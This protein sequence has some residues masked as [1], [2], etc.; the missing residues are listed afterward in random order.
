MNTG[1]Q[2]AA[3]TKVC[4]VIYFPIHTSFFCLMLINMLDLQ[5]ASYPGV[6][7]KCCVQILCENIVCKVCVKILC[8]NIVCKYCVNILCANFVCKVLGSLI[9][10]HTANNQ[11][12]PI[13]WCTWNSVQ[14]Y[15]KVMQGAT[16]AVLLKKVYQIQMLLEVCTLAT[17]GCSGMV[18]SEHY[19]LCTVHKS[20]VCSCTDAY[21]QEQF[22][23]M[24]TRVEFV[25]KSNCGNGRSGCCVAP[26]LSD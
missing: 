8:E 23:L 6:V 15:K 24:C 17:G 10:V 3:G 22:A 4:N 7:C 25:Q 16:V 20:T 13:N 19:E 1:V 5:C 9:N 18:W 21:A 26:P 14:N 2:P 11:R 12:H